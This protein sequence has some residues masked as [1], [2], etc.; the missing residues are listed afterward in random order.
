MIRR[1]KGSLDF[2]E[3]YNFFLLADEVQYSLM[4]GISQ[5]GDDSFTYIASEIEDRFLLGVLAGKNLIIASNTMDS[6]VYIELIEYMD[7]IEYPGIIGT[8]KNC[9]KYNE[10]YIKRYGKSLKPKM[11]QRIYQCGQVNDY[12]NSI[13]S[14]RLASL[15]DVPLLENW[16]LDFYKDIESN[17]TLKDARD[18][19]VGKIERQT[20]YVLIVD[21][22]IV[23]MAARARSIN[24]TE[25]VG[26]VYTPHNHR[27]KGYASRIVEDITRRIHQDGRIAT[28]YTDLDNPTS[29]SIYMKIG[30]VPHCD[31]VML[32]K[33]L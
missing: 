30:Y 22:E 9:E 17:T 25:T 3:K 18:S 28:L 6:E 31:S 16:S 33:Q 29:N 5:K 13:G 32:N 1:Y 27:R 26:F 11:N 24:K 19:V 15:D 20:I 7:K 23:S 2:L 8:R 4:L 12:S 21:N 10:Q 14:I